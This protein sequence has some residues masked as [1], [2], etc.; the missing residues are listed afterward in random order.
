MRTYE[1]WLKDASDKFTLNMSEIRKEYE[2]W[3][4]EKN[5]ISKRK[6]KD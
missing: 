4:D 1:E 3:L 6:L 5:K 2:E